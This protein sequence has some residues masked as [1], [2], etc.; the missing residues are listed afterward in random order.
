MD[1]LLTAIRELEEQ[2]QQVKKMAENSLIKKEWLTTHE[3]ARETGLKPK[4]V[5]NYA[6]KG[7]FSQIRKSENGKHQ[8]HK[9]ELSKWV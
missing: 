2:V 4:T 5:S 7:K 3:F 6:S 8:I 1:D 9:S